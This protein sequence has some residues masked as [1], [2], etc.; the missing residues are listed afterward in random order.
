MTKITCFILIS[1]CL[2]ACATKDNRNDCKSPLVFL[3]F[4]TTAIDWGD[5]QLN[6]KYS[7][8]TKVYN[9]TKKDVLIKIHH[10]HPEI[11]VFKYGN[12]ALDMFETGMT[13]SSGAC[14]SLQ[15]IFSPR[16]LSLIGE[17]FKG[18]HMY[19]DGDLL[20]SP[21]EMSATIIENFDSLDIEAIQNRPQIQMNQD[22]IDFGVIK[23]DEV[24][25]ASFTIKNV[26]ARDLIIRKVETTCGCAIVEPEDRIVQPNKTTRLKVKFNS[27]GVEGKLYKHVRL[28]TNDPNHPVT[29]LL[30]TSF[31]EK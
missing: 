20:L 30:L 12:D 18:I 29:V 23:G 16:D 22:T 15:V 14:D 4:R 5:V 25:D 21:I 3:L 11:N 31:V 28:F 10:E 24:F 17:Y 7:R 8:V 13:L 9:P 1:F 19:V 2:Y 6:K 26:G 27:S